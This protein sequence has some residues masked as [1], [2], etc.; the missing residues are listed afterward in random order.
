MEK[1]IGFIGVD[2]VGMPLTDA[3]HSVILFKSETDAI[4]CGA[5]AALKLS[6]ANR[7]WVNDCVRKKEG[8]PA[9]KR[10]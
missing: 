10:D 2:E 5:T 7:K 1:V 4:A 9:M 3:Y 6:R 8:K